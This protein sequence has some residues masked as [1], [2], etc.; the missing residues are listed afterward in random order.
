MPRAQVEQILSIRRIG[1]KPVD[2]V[3]AEAGCEDE[4]IVVRTAV[5]GV[6][7]GAADQRVVAISAVEG[8]A[9]GYTGENVVSALPVPLKLPAPVKVRFSTLVE[10]V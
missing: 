2:D 7:A 9:A 10:S 1:V 6:V 8:V 5:H 4:R 3:I